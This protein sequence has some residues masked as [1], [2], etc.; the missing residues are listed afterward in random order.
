MPAYI[1]TTE[2]EADLRSVIRY[3]RA[4]WGTPQVRRYVLVLERGI[5]SLAEGRGRSRI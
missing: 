4:Q 2:A 3:T 1:L 5:T